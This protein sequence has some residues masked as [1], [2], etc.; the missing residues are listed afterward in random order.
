[1]VRALEYM[2]EKIS[3]ILMGMN[4]Y[5]A[6]THNTLDILYAVGSFCCHTVIQPRSL[7][8]NVRLWT[9]NAMSYTNCSFL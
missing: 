4:R 7:E 1:M 5:E 3:A 8:Y 9:S 6:K 2:L